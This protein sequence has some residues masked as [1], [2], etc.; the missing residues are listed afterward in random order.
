[1]QSP[2]GSFISPQG[3]ADSGS[4]YPSTSLAMPSPGQRNWPNSPSVQGPS[5]ASRHGMVSSPGYPTLHSPQTQLKDE[6]AKASV[7]S[8]PSRI[9]PQRAWAAAMP[10]L[11]SHE[12]FD[13]LLNPSILQQLPFHIPLSPLE[14]FLGC[15]FIRRHLL[16][17]I[18]IEKHLTF[19]ETREPGSHLFQADTLQFKITMN[20]ST[21][22]SLHMKIQPL[23]EYKDQWTTEEIQILER[24]FDLK[25]AC[26]PYKSN[27]LTSFGRLLKA[28]IRILKDCV[29]IMR[30]ELMP[31]QDRSLKWSVQWLL[32]IPPSYA[33]IAPAGTPAVVVMAKM[34]L[35]LQLTRI[36]LQVPQEPQ[37]ITIPLLYDISNNTIT[38][39]EKEP[40]LPNPNLQQVMQMLKRFMER[41]H[42]SQECAIYPAVRELMTNL[43]LPIG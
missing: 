20:T 28:Q 33:H 2:A 8:P 19:L 32:T 30:L 21:L 42:S 27:S 1:M 41:Y 25:V 3:V 23:P 7:M 39:V 10:T 5:P 4:P 15:N 6:H 31:N 22:Q 35:M 11:L 18:T 29:Q 17:M 12:A 36:G 9:L 43:V 26:P 24:Y 34:V 13:T 38:L 40:S 16:R 37:S 14:R